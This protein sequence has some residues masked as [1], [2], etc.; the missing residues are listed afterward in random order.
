MSEFFRDCVMWAQ[1][2]LALIVATLLL[3]L[4]KLCYRYDKQLASHPLTKRI[5][6]SYLNWLLSLVPER[7]NVRE[8]EKR[9]QA[10]KAELEHF[11]GRE[12]E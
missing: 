5:A 2:I 12:V 7:W 1:I 11:L 6:E 3:P 4:T 10:R 9:R 8:K